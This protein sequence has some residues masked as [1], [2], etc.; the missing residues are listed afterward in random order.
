MA[1]QGREYRYIGPSDLERLVR[2]GRGGRGGERIETAADFARWIAVRKA[3][4]LAEPFTFVIDRDG[5]LR[6]APRRTEHVVCAE[7][8]RVASAGEISFREESGSWAIDEVSNQST[9]Y[10]PD[11]VSWTAVAEALDRVGLDHPGR[12][13][14]EVIFRRCTSCLQVNVVREDFFVC[15]FCDNDLPAEWNVDRLKAQRG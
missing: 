11:V 5:L 2:R 1:A 12:F 9:G 13:T 14:H 4:E 7:G 15:V 10:C 6:L 3:E 8:D